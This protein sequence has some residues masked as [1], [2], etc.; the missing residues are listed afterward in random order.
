MGTAI[1]VLQW[2]DENFLLVEKFEIFH[3]QAVHR[4][5]ENAISPKVFT[6]FSKNFPAAVRC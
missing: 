5:R 3:F 1:F 6:R 2:E 4:V